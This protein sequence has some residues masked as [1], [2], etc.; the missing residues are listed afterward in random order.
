MT[1]AQI[2]E[3]LEQKFGDKIRVKKLDAIDP[4]AVVA[5]SDL[6]EVCR[7]LRDDALLADR[8]R[9]LIMRDLLASGQ[10]T[11]WASV[12]GQRPAGLEGSPLPTGDLS[13]HQYRTDGR[14]YEVRLGG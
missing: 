9:D 11:T 8:E 13:V 2:I 5:P 14:V 10:V 1:S 4:F 7:F 12:Q 3:I 6:L